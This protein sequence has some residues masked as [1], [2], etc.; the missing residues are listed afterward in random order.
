MS[1]FLKINKNDE[2]IESQIDCME[3]LTHVNTYYEVDHE[4]TYLKGGSLSWNENKIKD[5]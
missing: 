4:I 1:F 3:K 5:N 2:S